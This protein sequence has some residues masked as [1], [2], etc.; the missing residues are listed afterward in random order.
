MPKLCKNDT[1]EPLYHIYLLV[2]QLIE[3]F[4]EEE[5]NLNNRSVVLQAD[6]E[7]TME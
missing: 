7:N 1:V 4:T 2:R 5:E 6:V 3:F